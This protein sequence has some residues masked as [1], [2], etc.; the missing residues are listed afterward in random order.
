LITDLSWI[1]FDELASD[2]AILEMI[3]D[4]AIELEAEAEA[5]GESELAHPKLHQVLELRHQY[6]EY[7]WLL[8]SEVTCCI[9]VLSS[10]F[11]FSYLLI[12]IGA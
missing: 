3:R 12:L 6:H 2:R 8:K 1:A 10:L 11:V 5:L 4:K 9:F 7:L